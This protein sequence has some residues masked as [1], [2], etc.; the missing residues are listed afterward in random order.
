MDSPRVMVLSSSLTVAGF[1]GLLLF[2]FGPCDSSTLG[3]ASFFGGGTV[4]CSSAIGSLEIAFGF[5]AVLPLAILVAVVRGRSE[6][7]LRPTLAVGL[8]GPVEVIFSVVNCAW[9]L[10]YGLTGGVAL[11]LV[12]LFGGV[13]LAVAQSP[14]W[15]PFSRGASSVPWS[16]TGGLFLAAAAEGYWFA[17]TPAPLNGF[18]PT[19]GP[20]YCTAVSAVHLP[21]AA[22]F[23]LVTAAILAF[24]SAVLPTRNWPGFL[25]AGMV[26]ITVAL[27]GIPATPLSPWT[28]SYALLFGLLGLMLVVA[29]AVTRLASGRAEQPRGLR[30]GEAARDP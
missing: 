17:G 26:L 14:A 3:S 1:V 5:A 21:V 2:S 6:W 15:G 4:P 11:S 10:S 7:W 24:V 9:T 13:S 27:S 8:F 22:F 28:N 16:L 20:S 30:T 12:I 19:A 25:G 18:L 29:T 23:A